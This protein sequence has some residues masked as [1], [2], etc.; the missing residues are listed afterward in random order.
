MA[1]VNYVEIPIELQEKYQKF[2]LPNDRYFNSRQCKKSQLISKPRLQ[3]LTQRSILPQIKD[4]WNALSAGDKLLWKTAGQASGFTGYQYFVHDKALR[5]KNGLAG[6]ATP[7]TI[8]QGWVG[9]LVIEAPDTNL[10]LMQAHPISYWIQRKKRGTKSQYE[11]VNLTEISALPLTIAI[12]YASALTDVSGAPVA[13][14]YA[15]IK[16]EYQ[17][18]VIETIEA[19]NFDLTSDWQR[20]TRT[21]NN[22][23]GVF[24]S[25]A[26]YIELDGVQGK[27]RFDNVR[28]EH[29]G[30]NWA[31][32]PK[33]NKIEQTFTRQFFNV[34]KHWVAEEEGENTNYY[35][36]YHGLTM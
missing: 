31:R 26:L 33:C 7:D 29:S 16:S 13:R 2:I 34:P 35:S 14:F 25:Y 9:E 19:I 10:V 22:V 24:R 32:D 11:L 12:S 21:I 20:Q 23:R 6:T 1:K 4:E 30:Q 27:L 28:A 5:I 3:K 17:G 36:I 15:K 8:K 18:R